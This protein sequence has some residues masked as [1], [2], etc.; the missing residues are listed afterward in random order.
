LKSLI[1]RSIKI[2]TR[3]VDGWFG[4]RCV[5]SAASIAFF[6]LF[7]LAPMLILVVTVASYGLK[8]TTVA[9]QIFSQ[10]ELTIGKVAANALQE[11]VSKA[12]LSE[13]G[14]SAT[15][16]SL[17]ITLI[18]ASA[19]FTELK[20]ALNNIFLGP[21]KTTPQFAQATWQFFR[22]RILSGALV[23]AIGGF[24]IIA[25]IAEGI[26]SFFVPRISLSISSHLNPAISE[27]VHP[28]VVL[29]NLLRFDTLTSI[30]LLSAS[31]TALLILLPDVKIRW[32]NALLSA[33]VGTAL[34]MAGKYAFGFYIAAAGTANAFGAAGSAVVTLMWFFYSAAVFLFGA[35]VLKAL[36]TETSFLDNTT[37]LI[38]TSSKA[39]HE[40]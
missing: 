1:T 23:L 20:A 10:L 34:F 33:F 9:Q 36:Q 39:S 35:E 32:Q 6:A 5:S 16:A 21:S 15:I 11:T 27:A 25:V 28:L 22:A 19:T 26:A 18:G 17:F 2:I 40:N 12:N 29:V 31:F 3:A 24:M 30:I 8:S 37:N 7:S 14:N 13:W 4:D 38:A